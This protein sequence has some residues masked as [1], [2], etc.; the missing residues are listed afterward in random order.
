MVI[1]AVAKTGFETAIPIA[2]KS[3]YVGVDALD[4]RG[5]ILGTSTTLAGNYSPATSRRRK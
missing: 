3:N 1:G 4:T 5:R 2:G